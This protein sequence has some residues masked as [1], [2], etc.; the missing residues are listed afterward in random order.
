MKYLKLDAR[1]PECHGLARALVGSPTDH[2]GQLLGVFD[3]AFMV[4][5]LGDHGLRLDAEWVEVVR[6]PIATLKLCPYVAMREGLRVL[7]S[8]YV[9]CEGEWQEIP[10][11]WI[12]GLI[13]DLSID[14]STAKLKIDP[15]NLPKGAEVVEL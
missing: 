7:F 14:I 4:V 2:Q 13:H 9:P 15:N 3:S 12:N 10:M 1:H 8:G 5:D 6:L 11:L